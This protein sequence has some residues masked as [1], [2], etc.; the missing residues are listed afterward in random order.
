MSQLAFA[1]RSIRLLLVVRSGSSDVDLKL[2]ESFHLTV[3]EVEQVFA[4]GCTDGNPDIV[5]IESRLPEESW[6]PLLGLAPV[7]AIIVGSASVDHY[8]IPCLIA[9]ARG[10]VPDEGIPREIRL[11]VETVLSGNVYAGPSLVSRLFS[12]LASLSVPAPERPRESS[13][14]DLSVAETRVLRLVAQGLSNQGIADTLGVSRHTVA[15]HVHSLLKKLSAK[16][17]REA[18]ARASGEDSNVIPF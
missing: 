16:N 18:V 9:G 4:Q 8:V 17:R 6:R 11:A 14:A 1:H 3:R 5:L 12:Y 7:P 10:Y 13:S 2:E 15:N